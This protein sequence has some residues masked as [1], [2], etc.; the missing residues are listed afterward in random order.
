MLLRGLLNSFQQSVQLAPQGLR[1]SFHRV[2][3]NTSPRFGIRIRPG[4][5]QVL[6]KRRHTLMGGAAVRVCRGDDPGDLRANRATGFLNLPAAALGVRVIGAQT[7]GL[8][9]ILRGQLFQRR[10]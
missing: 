6:L 1:V 7:A 2:K 3:R 8:G 9:L 10:P 5:F 4:I